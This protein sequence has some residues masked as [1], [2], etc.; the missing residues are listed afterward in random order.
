MSCQVLFR[1]VYDSI[2]IQF[3]PYPFYIPG[4]IHR[5]ECNQATQQNNNVEIHQVSCRII[6][7]EFAY[8]ELHSL[9][10]AAS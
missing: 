8:Y 1:T 3:Y 6:I 9:I 5:N 2:H 7:V 10:A 4:I